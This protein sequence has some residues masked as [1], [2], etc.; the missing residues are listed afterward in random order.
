MATGVIINVVKCPESKENLTLGN[1]GKPN[2]TPTGTIR[3]KL[4]VKMSKLRLTFINNYIYIRVHFNN[5]ENS[6]LTFSCVL[7]KFKHKYT[8]YIYSISFISLFFI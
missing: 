4:K 1:K 5:K 6:F 7:E 3:A 2:N 8:V